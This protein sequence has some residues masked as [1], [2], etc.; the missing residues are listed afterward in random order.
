V[1]SNSKSW[2]RSKTR[3]IA[4]SFEGVVNFL[5]GCEKGGVCVLPH[6]VGPCVVAQM[7]MGGGLRKAS[8][9]QTDRPIPTF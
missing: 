3:S 6:S 5:R 9:T 1:F 8:T 4:A 7:K 2:Y